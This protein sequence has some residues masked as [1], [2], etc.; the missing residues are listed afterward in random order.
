MPDESRGTAPG[1]NA[2][3]HPR[4]TRASR[5]AASSRGTAR[6]GTIGAL[7]VRP[8]GLDDLEVIAR[9]RVALLREEAGNPLFARAHPRALARARRLTRAQLARDHEVIFLAWHRSAPVGVL[10]CRENRTTPLVPND[11]GAV[12][13]TAYVLSGHRRRGVLR[14]LLGAADTWCRQRGL[15]GMRLR[16]GLANTGGQRAWRALGFTPAELLLVRPVPGY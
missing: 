10:R 5:F 2:R 7:R 8:A 12:V 14:A 13:T 4:R 11:R 15:S 6:S 3:D 1:G 16:C 9:L